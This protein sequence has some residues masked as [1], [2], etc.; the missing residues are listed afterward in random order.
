MAVMVEEV[1]PA[2]TGKSLRVKLGGTWYGAKLDSGLNG[3]KGKMIEAEIT[4]GKFGPWIDA[5]RP[6]TAAPQVHPPTQAPSPAPAAAAPIQ[7]GRY[8]TTREPVYAEP[9][10]PGTVAPYWLPFASNT[11]NA[12]IAAGLIK[13][14]NEISMWVRSA[15]LAAL[16]ADVADADGIPF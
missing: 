3:S 6:S 11:V 5:W 14:P 9:A 10:K 7:T 12:A 13:S 2:K 8:E 16:A 1:M 4:T 15:Q